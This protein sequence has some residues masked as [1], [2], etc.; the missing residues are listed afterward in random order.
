MTV[1]SETKKE[2]DPSLPVWVGDRGFINEV[3]FAKEFL[4]FGY[5][6]CSD[7]KFYSTEGVMEEQELRVTIYNIISRYVSSN[8]NSKITKIL[9][10]MRLEGES[11][12]KIE[13]QEDRIHLYNGTLYVDGTFLDSR[14]YCMNRLPA[15]YKKDAPEPTLWLKFLSELLDE[16]DIPTLQ[17]YM[18]YLFIPS[19]RAQK[20]LMIIGKGGEGKSRIGKVLHALLGN[21]MNTGNISKVE[22]NQFARADL[23]DK[24]LLLDDDLKL[25]ALPQTNYIKSIITAELPMDLEKKGVQSYQGKLYVRFL[26]L[27]NGTLQS[28]NDHSFGF[29]RR[30]IIITTKDRPKDR[31]DDPYLADKLINEADGIFKWCFEGLQRL[32]K[33]NFQFTISDRAKRNLAQAM[34]DSVNVSDFMTS[35]GYIERDP[36]GSV[37][38]KELY[39][40]YRVWCSDNN[41]AELSP[42]AFS[43]FLINHLGNYG[44]RYVNRL[45]DRNRAIRGFIGLTTL[46]TPRNLYS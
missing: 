22:T 4:G 46:I 17:E 9:S 1:M 41:V 42:K 30:Q 24:L 3:E 26:G 13:N 2:R 10:V 37:S 23:E 18:G 32:V 5:F 35:S 7:G 12:E 39:E 34:R 28:M 21:A 15:E 29:F 20:M 40:V 33:N 8:V 14:E 45:P 38:T 31:V 16:S 11:F 6:K 44:L 19:T 43:A 25:E 36:N 27:G